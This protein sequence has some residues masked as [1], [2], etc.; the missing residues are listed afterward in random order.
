MVVDGGGLPLAA[1]VTGG[2]RNDG[3]MLAQVLADVRVPRRGPGRPR[4]TPD[5][6][7]ADRAYSS[8]RAIHV[9]AHLG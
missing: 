2:Q 9:S 4:T 8:K 1:V 7:L 6:V 3:A 5:T